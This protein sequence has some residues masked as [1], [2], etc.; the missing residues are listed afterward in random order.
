[1]QTPAIEPEGQPDWIALDGQAGG[2]FAIGDSAFS[3]PSGW[4]SVRRKVCLSR[5]RLAVHVRF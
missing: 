2:E 3:R 4:T 5:M 1:M